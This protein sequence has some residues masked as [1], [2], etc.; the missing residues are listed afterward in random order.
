MIK[1]KEKIVINEKGEK[2]SVLLDIKE[3]RKL[4]KYIEDLEDV[5]AYDKGKKESGGVISFEQAVKDIEKKYGTH[6]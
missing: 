3:Y 5:V 2:S 4:L 1:V 6:L